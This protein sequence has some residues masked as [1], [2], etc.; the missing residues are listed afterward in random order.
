MI[1]VM[2]GDRGMGLHGSRKGFFTGS[3]WDVYNAFY[4]YQSS[5]PETHDTSAIFYNANE[6]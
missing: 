2:A 4:E 5:L 1:V 3:T 6:S